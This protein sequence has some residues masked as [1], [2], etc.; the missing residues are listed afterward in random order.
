MGWHIPLRAQYL[1]TAQVHSVC[2]LIIA[3]TSW[4]DG[5]LR[6]VG[7]VISDIQVRIGSFFLPTLRADI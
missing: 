5:S 4:P 3:I 2:R 1:P 7:D 6:H